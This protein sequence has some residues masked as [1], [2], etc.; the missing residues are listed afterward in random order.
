MIVVGIDPGEVSGGYA[1]RWADGRIHGDKMKNTKDLTSYLRGV[2]AFKDQETYVF[3]EKAQSFPKQGIASAFNY[4]RHFGELL[5]IC[6][7]LGL[8]VTLVHPRVWTKQMHIGAKTDEP[9]KRSLEVCQRLFPEV[10]LLGTER[11]KNPHEGIVDALL[12]MEFGRRQ[13]SGNR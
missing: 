8:S 7:S 10:N 6:G 3:I 9:K 11:S 13:L 5:G 2:K 4:G 1:T 12:I